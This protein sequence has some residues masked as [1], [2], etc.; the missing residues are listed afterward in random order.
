MNNI[1][2][3]ENIMKNIPIHPNNVLNDRIIVII[4]IARIVW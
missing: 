1:K 3:E 2:I 4:I